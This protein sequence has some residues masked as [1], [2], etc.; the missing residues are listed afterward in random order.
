MATR[1]DVVDAMR[2]VNPK[3]VTILLTGYPAFTVKIEP[4]MEG[5]SKDWKKLA[6][7]AANEQDPQKL[8]ALVEELNATLEE[9]ANQLRGPVS[10]EPIAKRLLFVDDEPSIRLTLA[11]LLQQHG[12][13]VRVAASVPEAVEEIERIT[14]LMSSCPT[15]TSVRMATD[16]T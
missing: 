10:T 13:D 3:C 2:K 6:Q 9:H 1:F 7:A 5:N 11:P 4:F 14:N 12:F 16:S 15:S 8:L